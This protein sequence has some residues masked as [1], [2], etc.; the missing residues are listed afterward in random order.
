MKIL[1]NMKLIMSDEFRPLNSSGPRLQYEL[2]SQ[3]QKCYM[4]HKI[5]K[6]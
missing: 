6:K 3:K 2:M 1:G 4:D 5:A